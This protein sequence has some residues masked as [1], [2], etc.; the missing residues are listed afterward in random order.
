MEQ[1]F[2]PL[3][4]DIRRVEE[5]WALRTHCHRSLMVALARQHMGESQL[6]NWTSSGTSSSS[7]PTSSV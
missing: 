2:P 6:S 4:R 5:L 1:P 7:G 3:C